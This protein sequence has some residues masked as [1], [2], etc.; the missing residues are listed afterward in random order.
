MAKPLLVEKDGPFLHVTL[1][2]PRDG[3]LVTPPMLAALTETATKAA[4]EPG[5]R[6]LV[7][8]GRG[9]DFCHGRVG[10]TGDRP[11]TALAAHAR[12]MGP[13]LRGCDAFRRLPVPGLTLVQ[14]RAPG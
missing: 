14:G 4:K 1:N 9:K 11:P 12:I 3:N 8:R 10:G 7:L 5:L 13:I 6:A 2:R